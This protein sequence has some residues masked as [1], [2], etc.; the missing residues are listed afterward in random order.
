MNF[1]NLF[2][3][4]YLTL[5]LSGLALILVLLR[6]VR[7]RRRESRPLTA[8]DQVL[9]AHQSFT[10]HFDL[11]NLG[12]QPMRRLAVVTCMDARIPVESMLGLQPGEAHVLRNAGGIVTEDT[13]RSL[14]ISHHV[15]ATQEILLIE[16]TDCGLLRFEDEDFRA[17]L[18]NQTGRN[19]AEPRHFHAFHDLR[20]SICEQVQRVRSHP[21]LPSHL[22]VRG[23]IYDVKTGA[24]S[25]VETG[26][27][28]Q[29]AI[30]VP[31]TN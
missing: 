16:H 7:R 14:I 15:L 18:V 23:F 19:P 10:R 1:A 13:L 21:W 3:A 22:V 17:Y 11:Q 20:A 24:L 9:R 5:A 6:I 2:A 28:L 4:E 31:N 30:Q 25:E 27:A 26:P 29:P 12:P 8:I